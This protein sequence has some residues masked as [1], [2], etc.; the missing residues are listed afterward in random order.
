M[1]ASPGKWTMSCLVGQRESDFHGNKPSTCLPSCQG[2]YYFFLHLPRL[3]LSQTPL[4]PRPPRRHE[5]V[6]ETG[7]ETPGG[8]ISGF[9]PWP[10]RKAAGYYPCLELEFSHSPESKAGKSYSKSLIGKLPF[11]LAGSLEDVAVDRR[12]L[13]TV[14]LA[15][16]CGDWVV[17]ASNGT[18]GLFWWRILTQFTAQ[19][20]NSQITEEI[21]F[22]KTV[23]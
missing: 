3:R 7:L 11:R 10:A 8:V 17:V 22:P 12:I 5:R 1:A 13:I 16:W 14:S 20:C 19:I 15:I 9:H 21:A 23:P 18:E 4:G 2:E 6:R